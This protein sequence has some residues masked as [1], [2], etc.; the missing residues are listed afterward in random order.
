VTDARLERYARLLVWAAP[1]WAVLLFIGT[2][3]H[4]PSPQTAFPEYARFITTTPFLI[5]HL[6]A[7]IFG[8][9][10]GTLGL[11]ALFIL[12]VRHGTGSSALWAFT[13]FTIGNTLATSVFGAAAFAQ[14]AIGR[15]YLAGQ[16]AQAVA[17]QD[18]V[19][20]VPLFTTAIPGV[21]LL[22]IGLVVFGIAAAR[23]TWVPRWPGITLAVSGPLFGII[24]L[25]LASE[26]QSVGAAGLIVSTA[27]IAL[28]AN[29]PVVR[30]S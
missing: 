15:M 5:S 3:E 14:P 19:Y 11:A 6:I 10:F 28:F 2:L 12:L 30:G 4:Q 21:L 7:S 13:L 23:S 24:G 17:L 26:V 20:G 1:L 8:A 16:T 22:T 27:A 18:D 25:I 29:R 9:A